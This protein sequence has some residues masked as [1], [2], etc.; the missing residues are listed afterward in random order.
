MNLPKAKELLKDHQMEYAKELDADTLNS[1]QVGI[2]AI[3]EVEEARLMD[4]PL[5]HTQLPSETKD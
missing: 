4:S 5:P 1:I 2:E 3:T